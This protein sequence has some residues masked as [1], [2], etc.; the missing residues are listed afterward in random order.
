MAPGDVA[1]AR[2]LQSIPAADGAAPVTVRCGPGGGLVGW[3]EVGGSGLSELADPAAAGA[4]RAAVLGRL[5]A[6]LGA[7][8]G[9]AVDVRAALVTCPLKPFTERCNIMVA[10]PDGKPAATLIVPLCYDA[11]TDTSLALA[12]LFTGRTHQIRVHARFLGHPVCGDPMHGIPMPGPMAARLRPEARAEPPRPGFRAAA[13]AAAGEAAAEAEAAAGEAGAAAPRQTAMQV[14]LAAFPVRPLRHARGIGLH[15]LSMTLQLC[16]P[17]GAGAGPTRPGFCFVAGAGLPAWAHP[18]WG[19]WHEGAEP[20][21]GAGASLGR[22]VSLTAALST[23]RSDR[24]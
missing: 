4:V 16:P 3:G 12:R 9:S 10:A 6:Q 18:A 23:L 20:C 14:A 1:G 15:C 22:M 13:S 7:D 2:R 24:W 8:P 17:A 5:S 21:A 19:G 11:A